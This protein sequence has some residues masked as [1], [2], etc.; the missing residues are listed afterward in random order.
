[1]TAAPLRLLTHPGPIAPLRWDSLADRG[2][3]AFRIHLTRGLTLQDSVTTAMAELGLESAALTL[4]GGSFERLDYCLGGPRPDRPQVAAYFDPIR[5]DQPVALV[6]ACATFGRDSAGA[7]LVHCHALMADAD[8]RAFG[9]HVVPQ[10]A[11]LGDPAPVA[12]VRAFTGVA[13]VQRADPE[14]LTTIFHPVLAGPH[15]AP[16]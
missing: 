5:L 8:G 2:A 14:T 15:D 3:R 13:I 1:M 7:P 4:M 9:G 11:R 6:G 12:F 10:T 16:H